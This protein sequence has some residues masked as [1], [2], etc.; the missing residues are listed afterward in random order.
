V[1]LAATQGGIRG[2]KQGGAQVRVCAS[3]LAYT[4]DHMRACHGEG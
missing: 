2:R 4:T 1:D 3:S